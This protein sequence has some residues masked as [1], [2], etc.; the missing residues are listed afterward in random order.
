MKYADL[1]RE[2]RKLKK[3]RASS[4]EYW[5]ALSEFKGSLKEAVYDVELMQSVN[6]RHLLQIIAWCSGYRPMEPHVV[7]MKIGACI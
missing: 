4:P 5:A 3:L 7:L 6:K 2:H 1:S